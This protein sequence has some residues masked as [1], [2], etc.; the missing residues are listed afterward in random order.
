MH[1]ILLQQ[2]DYTRSLLTQGTYDVIIHKLRPNP[3]WEHFLHE[4]KAAHPE[5]VIID[6]LDRIRALHNRATM[7]TPL[8]GDGITLAPPHPQQQQQQQQQPVRVQAPLQVEIPEGASE[9][10]AQ[11][12]LAAAGLSPPLLCKPLWTDGREGSHGLAVLHDLEELGRLLRGGVSSEFKPPLVVQEFVEHGGVLFKVYVLGS[13]TVVTARPSLGEAVLEAEQGV[14]QLPRISCVSVFGRQMQQQRQQQQQQQARAACCQQE[15]ERRSSGC[16]SSQ[17]QQQ[18]PASPGPQGLAAVAASWRPPATA[19]C[20]PEWVTSGLAATLRRELGMQLFNFDLIVPEQQAEQQQQ[21]EAP[22]LCYVVDIN[23]FPGVDKIVDFE[24]RFVKL[25]WEVADE[26]QEL[27]SRQ[28]QPVAVASATS[29]PQQEQQLQPVAASSSKSGSLPAIALARSCSL[30]H[31]SGGSSGAAAGNGSSSGGSSS[32]GSLA[33]C[34]SGG[35][36]DLQLVGSRRRS[37]SGGSSSPH[38]QRHHRHHRHSGGL[39][40]AGAAAAG[41]WG[42]GVMGSSPPVQVAGC[43]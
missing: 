20:P 7:L 35:F 19:A 28:Q 4:Y 38:A 14:Q 6:R 2:L 21:G 40:M 29:Q 11:A 9:A 27:R 26:Q 37:S 33:G 41:Q 32:R 1:G 5:V 24:A 13:Q 15:Q 8:K 12:A 36:G 31:H 43:S 16:C 34:G 18:Q 25:L 23:Y 22:P 39:E 30:S 42:D 17:Q 3:A 10:D